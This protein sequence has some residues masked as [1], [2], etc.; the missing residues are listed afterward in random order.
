MIARRQN[1]IIDEASKNPKQ[2]L[3]DTMTMPVKGAVPEG[4]DYSPRAA[5]LRIVARMTIKKDAAVSKAALEELEKLAPQLAPAAQVHIRAEL[6]EN[7]LRVGDEDRAVKALIE[8]V[9]FTAKI[10]ELDNEPGDPNRAFKGMWPSAAL[11]RRCIHYA[12]KLT[13]GEAEQII[14]EIPDSE[15]KSFERVAL[16]TALLG[17]DNPSLF[18]TVIKANQ[19]KMMNLQ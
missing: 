6:P 17:G 10:Y 1:E 5:T 3:A 12:V 11:W 16:G 7:Y 19:V 14:D 13:P 2:A 8:L 4:D 15:I 9:K 18:V